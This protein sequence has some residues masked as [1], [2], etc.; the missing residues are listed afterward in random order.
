[1]EGNNATI[2]SWVSNPT[3]E[4]KRV[5][6]KVKIGDNE[7]SFAAKVLQPNDETLL[8][9]DVEFP[10]VTPYTLEVPTLY[11]MAATLVYVGERSRRFH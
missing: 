8:E 5:T 11:T 1:M 4:E 7:V 2:R 10:S 6:F 3:N 9:K